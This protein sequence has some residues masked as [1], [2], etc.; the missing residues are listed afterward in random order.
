MLI[1]NFASKEV[2]SVEVTN[3]IRRFFC[4]LK[5]ILF[6]SYLC[7][8]PMTLFKRWD[9][10][11]YQLKCPINF[12]SISGSRLLFI[13]MYTVQA[14]KYKTSKYKLIKYIDFP[15]LHFLLSQLHLLYSFP[16]NVFQVIFRQI[17]QFVNS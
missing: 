9:K 8:F 3:K 11:I 16:P 10:I 4:N 2:I 6:L 7:I 15:L 12:I 14:R 1:N 13:I 17:V 5:E